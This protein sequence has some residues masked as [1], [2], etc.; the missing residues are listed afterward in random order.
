M[1]MSYLEHPVGS[2]KMFMSIRTFI[3]PTNGLYFGQKFFRLFQQSLI[4]PIQMLV[5]NNLKCDN[6]SNVQTTDEN[7]N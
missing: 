5:I 7:I 2:F 3:G 4:I 1:Y 6:F